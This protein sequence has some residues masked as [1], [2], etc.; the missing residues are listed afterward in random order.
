MS[1]FPISPTAAVLSVAVALS[2]QTASAQDKVAGSTPRIES[3]VDVQSVSKLTDQEAAEVSFAGGR[4][5]KHVAQ[6]RWAIRENKPSEAAKHVDQSLKLISII[7]QLLPR[8]KVKTEIKSGA[9]TYTDEDEVV[10]RHVTIFDELDRLDVMSPVVQAKQETKPVAAGPTSV[11]A[12]KGPQRMAI[13]HAALDYTA[14]RLDVSLAKQAL[15][16]AKKSLADGKLDVADAA[17]RESQTRGVTLEYDEI[18]LPLSEAADNLK[19]AEAEMAE[20][21]FDEARA[22]LNFAVDQLRHYETLVRGPKSAQ[23]AALHQEISKLTAE[24]AA[25]KPSREDQV[26]HKGAIA[27]WWQRVRKMFRTETR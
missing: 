9:T 17:L 26:K 8:H 25:G 6:A 4:V 2:A 23:V 15:A 13:T 12:A 11:D 27:G 14:V 19:L 16:A 1:R 7:E 24:L 22:A 10:P 3:R 20:G 5:L 21:R 18:D